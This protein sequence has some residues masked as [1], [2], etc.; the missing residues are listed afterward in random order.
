MHL[1]SFNDFYG[2]YVGVERIS[3]IGIDWY[4]FYIAANY[5]KHAFI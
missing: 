3:L 5:Q 1:Y 4:V 2:Y